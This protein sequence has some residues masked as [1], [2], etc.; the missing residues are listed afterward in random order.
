MAVGVKPETRATQYGK[1]Q[2]F[3]SKFTRIK[4]LLKNQSP[5]AMSIAVR[6]FARKERV[7][8]LAAY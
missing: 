6:N 2:T 3:Q 4:T 5:I 8:E 1:I 7:A